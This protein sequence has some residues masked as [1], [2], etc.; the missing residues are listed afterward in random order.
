MALDNG[1]KFSFEARP[2]SEAFQFVS[3]AL[4]KKHNPTCELQISTIFNPYGPIC[5]NFG[6]LVDIATKTA[7][8][9]G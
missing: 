6:G 5:G 9:N 2:S 8:V 7:L 3:N 4:Y 1:R